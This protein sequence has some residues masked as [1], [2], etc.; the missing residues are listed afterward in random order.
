LVIRPL[1]CALLIYGAGAQ[2]ARLAAAVESPT[3]DTTLEGRSI[4]FLDVA[5]SR[6][7]DGKLIFIKAVNTNREAAL[8][9]GIT[10]KGADVAPQAEV[11]T[12][13]AERL[14]TFNSFASP[15]AIGVRR[16]TINAGASFTIELPK[17]SVSVITLAVK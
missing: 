4:P 12:V 9:T 1:W 2:L 14:A 13:T 6:S 10:L 3:F 8:A 5:A 17:H 7:A 15:E 11:E 16:S